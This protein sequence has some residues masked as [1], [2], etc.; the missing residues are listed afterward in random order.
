MSQ[1][2]SHIELGPILPDTATESELWQEVLS[3]TKHYK[4]YDEPTK[5]AVS[6]RVK[7]NQARMQKLKSERASLQA[8]PF[9]AMPALPRPDFR[10]PAQA[11]DSSPTKAPSST[12]QSS[13]FKTE[14]PLADLRERSQVWK[15][16]HSTP[17][18]FDLPTKMFDTA[19]S[20]SRSPFEDILD[21]ERLA[22]KNRD[23]YK[24]KYYTS[25]EDSFSGSPAKSLQRKTEVKERL[26]EQTRLL[27]QQVALKG[28]QREL[29]SDLLREGVIKRKAYHNWL[30]KLRIAE[31]HTAHELVTLRRKRPQIES[32]LIEDERYSDFVEA[33]ADM[34]VIAIK[35]QDPYPSVLRDRKCHKD[36]VAAVRFVQNAVSTVS[37]TTYKLTSIKLT[38]ELRG[39]PRMTEQAI[40]PVEILQER[41]GRL[42][43]HPEEADEGNES[44]D[45]QEEVGERHLVFW[46]CISNEYIRKDTDTATSHLY[47]SSLG[48]Y[49]AANMF[50]QPRNE[51]HSVLWS[52]E[53]GLTT[54][55]QWERLLDDKRAVAIV[56][57]TDAKSEHIEYKLAVVAHDP[58]ILEIEVHGKKLSEWDGQKLKFLGDARPGAKYAYFHFAMCIMKQRMMARDG[59]YQ[60]TWFLD[61]W[62]TFFA[63]LDETKHGNVE[64]WYDRSC[65]K[66]LSLYLGTDQSRLMAT[67]FPFTKSLDISNNDAIVT[68]ITTA[69][70]LIDELEE[71]DTADK[72]Q[73][74][75]DQ[76]KQNK[77]TE[78]ETARQEA[79]GVHFLDQAFDDM[80]RHIGKN[81]EN[82]P[83]R[84]GA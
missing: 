37:D 17:P 21:K 28:A 81:D 1:A 6:V 34:M 24:R 56:P 8:G 3:L 60:A 52:V 22:D 58:A 47:P 49:N 63:T 73:E 67:L 16:E 84:S 15:A 44:E 77:E 42:K 82:D 72:L 51:G 54:H 80:E 59:M 29:L 69:A 40:G 38:E 46:D 23:K 79:V 32:N 57:D 43:A 31:G 53:N 12:T 50:G 11:F 48:Y 83:P 30:Q 33:Y 74:E 26:D 64:A 41:L 39:R 68:G 75:F 7:M 19:R 10:Q 27:E 9:Q 45:E 71:E 25:S 35:G 13:P 78:E 66:T 14:S 55:T 61:Q 36:W 70:K 62:S 18:G 4:D 2:E 76:M 65:L 20:T 5:A